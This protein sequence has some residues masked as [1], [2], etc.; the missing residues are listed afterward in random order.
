VSSLRGQ[1]AE[2]PTLVVGDQHR[3]ADV[4]MGICVASASL[5]VA[6]RCKEG[7]M[8]LRCR[9]R[10]GWVSKNQQ[11]S[12]RDF[13]FVLHIEDATFRE[14]SVRQ[15]GNVLTLTVLSNVSVGQGT[16]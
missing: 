14:S 3:L 1:A 2:R 12:A 8:R 16:L 10:A 9:S 15:R 4:V 13:G 5:L 7:I 11:S 6:L